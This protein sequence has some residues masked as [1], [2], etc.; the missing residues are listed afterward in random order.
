MGAS[1]TPGASPGT[2]AHGADAPRPR[3]L[4]E[5]RAA[6][7]GGHTL[8]GPPEARLLSGRGVGWGT[9]PCPGKKPWPSRPQHAHCARD[10][11][12]DGQPWPR[13]PGHH[14][15]GQTREDVHTANRPTL[16]AGRS[17]E[18]TWSS[19]R[20]I[21][22]R[23]SHSLHFLLSSPSLFTHHLQKLRD[24]RTEDQGVGSKVST[25]LSLGT[26][27]PCRPPLLPTPEGPGT[28]RAHLAPREERTTLPQA[29]H[30]PHA[31]RLP[32]SPR[33]QGPHVARTG[34]PAQGPPNTVGG[35]RERN[36][37]PDRIN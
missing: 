4:S 18:R 37:F 15:A 28:A 24:Q 9:E 34:S 8:T 10:A 26:A 3:V 19:Q 27:Q 25:G 7:K 21:R 36:S 31:C 32:S 22:A 1:P 5:R 2:R 12:E 35:Q 11:Q 23:G 13:A 30:V 14:A 29:L 20:V 16:P 33:P 6:Q 17:P